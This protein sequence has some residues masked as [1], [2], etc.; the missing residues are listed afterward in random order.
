MANAK[1]AKKAKKATA[2][3]PEESTT[4]AADLLR[5]IASDPLAMATLSVSGNTVTFKTRV[6]PNRPVTDFLNNLVNADSPT[7]CIFHKHTI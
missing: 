7:H 3:A 5:E 4:D 2:P 1:K 6:N